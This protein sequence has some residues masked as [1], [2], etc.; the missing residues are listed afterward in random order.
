MASQH[1]PGGRAR[2]PRRHLPPPP[3]GSERLCAAPRGDP[4]PIRPRPPCL[5]LPATPGLPGLIPGNMGPAEQAP[6]GGIRGCGRNRSPLEVETQLLV[7]LCPSDFCG[8]GQV[9]SQPLLGFSSLL[10]ERDWSGLPRVPHRSPD[11]GFWASSNN[12]EP[13]DLGSWRP[14]RGW[15]SSC[16]VW[17]S[18]VGRARAKMKIKCASPDL[19]GA[20]ILRV[21]SLP[22]PWPL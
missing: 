20:D 7:P 9:I 1:S 10:N 6:P 22:S 3:Y 17:K 21:H 11:P 4:A 13:P 18:W 16:G 12:S 15:S 14:S 8:L 5:V 19:F 2:P